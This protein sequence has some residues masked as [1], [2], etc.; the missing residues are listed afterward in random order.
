MLNPPINKLLEIAGSRYAL[1]IAVSKRARKLID[2]ELPLVD[3]DS[4]KPISIATEEIYRGKI[5]IVQ[6]VEEVE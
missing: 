5:E 4:I 1:V 6:S 3:V 2:G